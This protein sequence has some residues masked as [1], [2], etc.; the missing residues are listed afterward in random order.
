MAFEPLEYTKSWENPEDFPT[1]EPNE[2][3]VRADL[4]LLHDEARDGLNRLIAALND[5]QAAAQLPF[6]PR[7][8]L[9]AQNVQDAI[10]EVYGA[11]RDAAAGLILN[12]SI[13]KEKLAQTLLERVYGGRI[14]VC[15][16]APDEADNPDTDYPVG[17]LWLR[18]SC[19]VENLLRT[20]WTAS[21]CSMTAASDGWL[22][23]SLGTQ[24]TVRVTRILKE[25]QE[26]QRVFVSLR[27][28]DLDDHLTAVK[29]YL[30]G[31][32]WDLTDGGGIRE[33]VLPAS[34]QLTLQITASWPY[35]EAGSYR[36]THAAAVNVDALMQSLEGC[37]P[38]ADWA[39]WLEALTPFETAVMEQALYLQTAPGQWQQVLYPVLP[40]D[41]GGT[42]KTGFSRDHLLLGGADGSMTELAPPEDAGRFLRYAGGYVWED[43]AQV[44]ADLGSLR[45]T[46]GTYQ[47]TGAGRSMTLPVA[48]KLLILFPE[49]GPNYVSVVGAPLIVDN[50]VILADGATK[51]ELWVRDVEEGYAYYRPS[52][53]LAGDVVSF[54]SSVSGMAYLGNRSGVRYRW[55]AVY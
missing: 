31:E 35:A 14:R 9:T 21:G 11:I 47:G 10:L 16:E 48:P 37:A 3:Q 23:T 34:G 1:Y 49:S 25:G 18:P 24:A 6:L 8:G 55:A 5:Q 54:S 43:P 30:N 52:V 42:G 2:A 44:V 53:K 45:L 40:V 41:Q 29:A 22:V 20:G 7:E 32:E 12:G 4:Q 27:T 15:A 26:G 19:T 46:T 13:T 28:A 51:A 38:A 33:A 17:Q 50:P 36:L 39:A